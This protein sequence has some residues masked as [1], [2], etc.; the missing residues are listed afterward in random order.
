MGES[1]LG[2]VENAAA[3]FD[4]KMK[5]QNVPLKHSVA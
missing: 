1:I 4:L 2:V 5:Q 3:R